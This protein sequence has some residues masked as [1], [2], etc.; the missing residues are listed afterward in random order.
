VTR[1]LTLSDVFH[2]PLTRE[3]SINKKTVVAIIAIDINQNEIPTKSSVCRFTLAD[4]KF[5]V[6]K[7]A[8]LANANLI[9]P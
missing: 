8:A 1:A 3:L 4:A 2:L 6:I 5:G 9:R 7:S